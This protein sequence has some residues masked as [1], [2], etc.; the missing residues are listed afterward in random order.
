MCNSDNVKSQVIQRFE[1]YKKRAKPKA[2]VVPG[3]IGIDK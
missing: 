2:D 3:S 1:E